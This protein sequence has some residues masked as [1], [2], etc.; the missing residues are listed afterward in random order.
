M[1]KK[2]SFPWSI[3]S[4]N[5]KPHFLGSVYVLSVGFKMA[6]LELSIFLRWDQHQLTFCCCIHW[7]KQPSIFCWFSDDLKH[8]FQKMFKHLYPITVL[9]IT[10]GH[11]SLTVPTAL[12]PP[13]SFVERS[14]RPPI[15]R[16]HNKLLTTTITIFAT[17]FRIIFT[18][19]AIDNLLKPNLQWGRCTGN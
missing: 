12:W 17:S 18:N 4:V 13:Q 19:F 16:C 9:K 2:W 14:P 11:R 8:L 3:S 6:I 15:P 1:H 7:E 5:R 10:A